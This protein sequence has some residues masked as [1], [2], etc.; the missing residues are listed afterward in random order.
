MARIIKLDAETLMRISS[1][2]IRTL[3]ETLRTGDDQAKIKA[4]EKLNKLFPQYVASK[5]D[6]Q[7]SVPIDQNK[8]KALIEAVAA[9]ILLISQLVE[10]K[11]PRH[12]DLTTEFPAQSIVIAAYLERLNQG[13]D[14]FEEILTKMFQE[15]VRLKQSDPQG[16]SFQQVL[17]Q[18]WKRVQAEGREQEDQHS[19]DGGI[20][21]TDEKLL[22]NLLGLDIDEQAQKDVQKALEKLVE[23]EEQRKDN[24]PASEESGPS[25]MHTA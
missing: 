9:P 19:S 20:D 23:N 13:Q 15:D 1:E 5:P 21:Y 17:D 2:M 6:I 22:S 18:A 16:T 7:G 11:D 8:R 24:G 12:G 14:G 3:E 25:P 10:Q 4:Q